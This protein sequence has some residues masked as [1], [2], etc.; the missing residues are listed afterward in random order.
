[1]IFNSGAVNSVP[2]N[3]G[4]VLTWLIGSM[5]SLSVSTEGSARNE[6]RLGSDANFTVDSDGKILVATYLVGESAFEVTTEGEL[7]VANYLGGLS[8]VVVDTDGR[9]TSV[10]YSNSTEDGYVYRVEFVDNKF[11]AMRAE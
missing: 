10:T 7:F 3:S 11:Y 4:K 5:S 6:V 2:I 1:M 8:N 9:I